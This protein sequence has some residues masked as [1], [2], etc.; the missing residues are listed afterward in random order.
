MSMKKVF[1]LLLAACILLVCTS[2]GQSTP[3]ATTA[4]TVAPTEV[5]TEVPTEAPTEVP[6][7]APTEVPTEAPTEVPTEAPTEAAAQS[8]EMTEE[9]MA[10]AAAAE[11]EEEEDYDAA[12]QAEDV[13]L[14][15]VNGKAVMLSDV[16]VIAD[17]YYEQYGLDDD[18]TEDEIRQIYSMAMTDAMGNE[19]MRQKAEEMGYTN[20]I[21]DE[22]A[23]LRTSAAAEWKEL[24]AYYAE[25]YFGYSSEGTE[26]D[27]N[28]ALVSTVSFLESYGYTEE[29]LVEEYVNQAWKD[30][31]TA[32]LCKDVSVTEDDAY[33]Y[34]LTCVESDKTYFE[35]NVLYYE[36]YSMYYGY[37]STYVPAGYRGVKQILLGVDETILANYTDLVNRMSA[38]T[39]GEATS[40]DLVTQEMVDE[41]KAA[42]LASVQDKVD[43]IKTRLAAGESFETLIAEYNTDE[44]MTIEPYA[45]N[46]Y[47]VHQDSITYDE[48]FVNAAFSVEKIG[49]VSEPY[50]GSYGV[51]IVKY[52]RDVPEGAVEYTDTMRASMTEA[53]QSER[54]NAAVSAQVNAWLE[55]ADIMYTAEAESYLPYADA[56]TATDAE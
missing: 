18:S 34:F 55:Q 54:E 19:I 39:S 23:E 8:D 10:A 44:G 33:A 1:A 43:A 52:I 13:A 26:E 2:C 6:T 42:V 48:A 45:T 22:K 40:T 46:G 17:Q 38:Q 25:A 32:D 37:Q 41:A 47:E 50:V 28:A 21:D 16:S 4:P 29:T 53:V 31:L 56:A 24:V 3:A 7:E 49:D 11:E 12:N 14:V 27:N 5:P 20:L 15:Y 51:Y 36:F 9:E 30:K 35:D